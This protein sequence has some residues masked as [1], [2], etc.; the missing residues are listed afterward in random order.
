MLSTNRTADSLQ[1]VIDCVCVLVGYGAAWYVAVWLRSKGLFVFPDRGITEYEEFLVLSLVLWAVLGGYMEI[2]HSHRSERLDFTAGELF[3]TLLIWAIATAAGVFLLK[4]HN[5]SRQFMLYMFLFSGLFIIARQL[6]TMAVMR[7]LRRF[8]YNWRTALIIGEQSN[9]ERFAD[10]IAKTYPMGYRVVLAPSGG[11][12]SE[13]SLWSPHHDMPEIE[14]AFIVPGPQSSDAYTLRLLKEGKSVHIVPELLDARLF[15]QALGDVAGIPVLS[16][17]NSKLSLLEA[18]AKR[19]ADLAGAIGLVILF[20]PLLA[21]VAL[22]VKLT[23]R[24]PVLFRQKR[25]GRS[26]QPFTLCK[27][28]TMVAHAEELLRA[29]PGLFEKYVEHNYKLPKGEDPRLTRIGSFLRATSLD[30][31][32]QLFNVIK[33]DMSLV[34][35]RPVVPAEVEKYGDYTFL[36]LSAKPGLTG[37]WQVSGRSDIQVYAQRVT[38]DLEYIRD[39]SFSKDLEI[40]LR[41]VPAV[42]LRRGAE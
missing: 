30:E 16:L 17:L 37:H 33:G 10:L 29:T 22:I 4:L 26:G 31:L 35:P 2:Y 13:S 11:G 9:C 23:S 28:R 40:L 36:F 18:A 27:F 19:G 5:I 7:R 38:L 20:A 21:A 42:L 25:L 14:D 15:R 32:P 12:A 6:L 8:G 24:G 3:R 1:R 41:T 34:G 39:Q